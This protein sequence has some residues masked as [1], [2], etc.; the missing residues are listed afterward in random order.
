M[1]WTEK[2]HASR[3]TPM[4]M[5]ESHNKIFLKETYL[6]TRPFIE[7]TCKQFF[8]SKILNKNNQ[9]DVVL[10]EV[11]LLDFLENWKSKE[12]ISFMFE[13]YDWKIY[14]F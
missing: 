11:A 10:W 2:P 9:G 4:R 1:F 13:S 6:M 5:G 14:I 7:V 12:M 8:S 3:L